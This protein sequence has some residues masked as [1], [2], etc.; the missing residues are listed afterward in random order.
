MTLRP[1]ASKSCAPGPVRARF[2]YPGGPPAPGPGPDR[3]RGPTTGVV[4]VPG[5]A[6]FM[7]PAA[8]AA[9]HMRLSPRPVLEAAAPPSRPGCPGTRA[10]SAESE[11]PQGVWLCRIAWAVW[12]QQPGD[13]ANRSSSSSPSILN[14]VTVTRD[15]PRPGAVLQLTLH[16]NMFFENLWDASHDDAIQASPRSNGSPFAKMNCL[17]NTN[18]LWSVGGGLTHS[19]P[20]D[21]N[22]MSDNAVKF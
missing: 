2:G 18:W 22:E 8:A 11:R 1:A 10:T 17:K 13:T 7:P 14:D 21:D 15:R 3:R 9:R 16:Q 5:P 19:N 12:N 6:D 20:H 4:S